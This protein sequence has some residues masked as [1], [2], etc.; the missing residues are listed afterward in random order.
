MTVIDVCMDGRD[1]LVVEESRAL[2]VVKVDTVWT[3]M[4]FG[5]A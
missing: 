3:V 5:P 2:S 1:G 4:V